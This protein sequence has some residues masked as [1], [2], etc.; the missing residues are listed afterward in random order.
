LVSDLKPKTAL[1]RLS[2]IGDAPCDD[3]VVVRFRP[4]S[5]NTS[6]PYVRIECYD[7]ANF[8]AIDEMDRFIDVIQIVRGLLKKELEKNLGD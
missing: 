6:R 7:S 4:C 2:M 1:M 8:M 5:K 3:E